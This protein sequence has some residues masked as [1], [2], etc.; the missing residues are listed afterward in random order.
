MHFPVLGGH[1][2]VEFGF[3]LLS[4]TLIALANL[5]GSSPFLAPNKLQTLQTQNGNRLIIFT[6]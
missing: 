2:A 3:L 5:L 4:F 1:L 6:L